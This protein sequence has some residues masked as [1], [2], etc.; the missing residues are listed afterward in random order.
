MDV[1]LLYTNEQCLSQFLSAFEP[2]YYSTLLHFI[3]H[4]INYFSHLRIILISVYLNSSSLTFR[5]F[6]IYSAFSQQ[7]KLISE[8]ASFHAI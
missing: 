7:L 3:S 5:F 2:V 8:T 4:N 1:V 6:T